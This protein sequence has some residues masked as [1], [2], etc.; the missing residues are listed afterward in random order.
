MTPPKK[1]L[2]IDPKV[3]DELIVP[4]GPRCM[5]MRYIV[6]RVARIKFDVVRAENHDLYVAGKRT[7]VTTYR[8]DTAQEDGTYPHNAPTI[9]TPEDLAERD[10]SIAATEYL[11][12]LGIEVWRMDRNKLDPPTLANLI[13]AHLGEEEI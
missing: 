9:Y 10:R 2:A 4:A 8:K 1:A 7:Y 6:V 3:G 5:E 11:R 13:R 12:K